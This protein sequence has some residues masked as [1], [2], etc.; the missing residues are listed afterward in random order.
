M[1]NREYRRKLGGGRKPIAART[2]FE[3]DV[4]VLRMGCQQRQRHPQSLSGMGTRGLLCCLVGIAWRWQSVDGGLLKA[5]L[6][7]LR[8]GLQRCG[9]HGYRVCHGAAY[10]RNL[11]C[12]VMLKTPCAGGV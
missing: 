12:G 8:H 10:W 9:W 3:E 11:N 5:S 6:A 7:R 4:H 2:L 1:G